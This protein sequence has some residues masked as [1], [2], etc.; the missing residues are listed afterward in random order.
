MNDQVP[1]VAAVLERAEHVH[2]E[3]SAERDGADPEWPLFYAWWLLTWSRLTELLGV[4]PTRSELAFELIAAD[5]EYRAEPRSEAWSAFYA[6]R[7]LA[8]DWTS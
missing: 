8:K 4:S 7:L 5:R 1:A 3:V 2:A 6:R